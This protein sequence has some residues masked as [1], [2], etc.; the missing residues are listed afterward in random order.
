MVGFLIKRPVAVL[1]SFLGATVFSILALINLPVSL[2]P[3]IQIPQIVIKVSAPDTSPIDVEKRILAQI[4]ES[5]LSINHLTN[6]ETKANSESGSVLLYFDFGTDMN[7]TYVAV[8]EGIDRLTASFPENLPRPQVIKINATDIPVVKLQVRPKDESRFVEISE[9]VENVLKKRIEQ[10]DGVSLVDINGLNS[11]EISISF[12]ETKLK[13]LNL[14][15]QEVN[16]LIKQSNQNL[17]GISVKNG[18]YRYFIKVENTLSNIDD[19]R[20]LPVRLPEQGVVLLS[21]I[22]T[23][24]Q[25][26]KS[27]QGLHLFQG[28]RSIVL[29]VHKQES[30]N[31]LQVVDRIENSVVNFENDYP[32]IE[33]DLSGDQSGL[34]EISLNN[35]K[36]SLTYGGIFAFLVLFLFFGNYRLPLIMGLSLP[37]TLVLS[38]LFFDLFGVTINIISL[39]GLALGLGML[40]DN[41]IIVVDNITQ[42]RESGMDLFHSVVTGVN[43]VI[44]ALLSSVLTT[45]AV[46]TPLVFLSGISGVLFKDQAISITIILILSLAVAFIFVALMYYLLFNSSNQVV[47]SDSR[48]FRALSKAYHYVFEKVMQKKWVFLVVIVIFSIATFYISKQLAVEGLPK[49]SRNEQKIQIDWNEPIT[50]EENERRVR[51]FLNTFQK[52]IEM[53]DSDLGL[54][55]YLMNQEYYGAASASVFISLGEV[56]IDEFTRRVRDYLYSE[57]PA[58]EVEFTNAPNAF[59]QLFENGL[60]FIEARV[61]DPVKRTSISPSDL[62]VGTENNQLIVPG[63]GFAQETVI[64]LE[65]DR[66]RL[67]LYGLVLSQLTNQLENVLGNKLIT[68]LKSY[69]S[70]I[71]LILKK[72]NVSIN[73]ILNSNFIVNKDNER[74]PLSTF[75]KVNYNTDFESVYA[76]KSGIYQSL[77]P[78]KNASAVSFMEKS[79]QVAAGNNWQLNFAGNYF[80]NIEQLKELTYVLIISVL[81]LYFILAALFESF[82]QPL[83]IIITIPV[84]VGGALLVLFLARST[85]NIMSVIG[86]IVM[87]GIIVNDSIL[88]VDTINRNRKVGLSIDEAMSAA[89]LSRLK[90]ILMTSITTILALLPIVFFKGVGAELQIPLVLSVVGGLTIGTL[91]SLFLIPVLYRLFHWDKKD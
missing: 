78:A 2:L 67:S 11:E 50:L 64:E 7:L 23:I 60:P 79:Q 49:I 54:R 52:D 22:A 8:N 47:T 72:E 12:D 19:L 90:P 44:P 28:E 65:V 87:I 24:K 80:E 9:F 10:I 37:L 29:N 68:E 66:R 15:V 36:S 13:S 59:D 84:T 39:S 75:L 38:F 34:L 40:I 42:K 71:E 46:F 35:L 74:Y 82:L 51:L 70:N 69:G 43:E 26:E 76:D 91:I 32:F 56:G 5:F 77:I 20:K 31:M 27:R 63:K 41:A 88:K 81:L 53:S 3:P 55:E 17:G 61:S 30:A 1:L 57:Y 62:Q 21:E 83:I 73:Q 48:L 25:E 18:Q 4:R 58:V 33:I 6:I 14:N 85:L 89:G 45:L 86:I 16:S